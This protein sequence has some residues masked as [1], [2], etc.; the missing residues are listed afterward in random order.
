VATWIAQTLGGF[1]MAA[2]AVAV[3][4]VLTT[5]NGL[6]LGLFSVAS[7]ISMIVVF[8][9]LLGSIRQPMESLFL[10]VYPLAAVCVIGSLVLSSGYEPRPQLPRGIELHALLSIVAYSILTLAACQALVFA[11]QEHRLHTGGSFTLLRAL[12]PLATME[13]LLFQLLWTGLAVLTASI[14][15]GF[16]F[17]EDMFAQHVVHHTVLSLSAWV[18]FAMLLWGH[19]ALGWRGV[20]AIR[21]TLTGFV[22]LMLAYFGSKL[23]IEI[24]LA[25]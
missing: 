25:G 16:V 14:I 4:L 19:H 11:F 23:V 7:L 5:P 17:L 21:W 2:Q 6:D 8:L 22:L 24:I 9:T 1:A 13:V 3:V 10:L 20:T 12:P 18:V 15:S